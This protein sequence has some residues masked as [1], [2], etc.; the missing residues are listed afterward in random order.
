MSWKNRV[1][2]I[3]QFNVAGQVFG[4]ILGFWGKSLKGKGN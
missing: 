2:Q 4:E 1:F 3:F